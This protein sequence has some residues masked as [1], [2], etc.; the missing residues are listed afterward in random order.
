MLILGFEFDSKMNDYKVVKFFY[1]GSGKVPFVEL[2]S[3]N[4]GAW[5]IIDSF[6]I[7]DV[8]IVE[9]V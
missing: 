9:C 1:P 3:I 8:K 5:L 6:S 4:K 7:V 2:Y